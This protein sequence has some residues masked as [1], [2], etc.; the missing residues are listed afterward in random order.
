M[1][2]HEYVH[3]RTCEDQEV[4]QKTQRM[5]EVLGPQEKARD[6]QQGRANEKCA[7][8]PETTLGP[9][10]VMVLRMVVHGHAYSP[11]LCCAGIHVD[12]LDPTRVAS[13]CIRRDGEANPDPSNGWKVK[14][15]M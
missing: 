5:R 13:A 7:R 12:L 2:V 3:Q 15:S 4:G 10:V 6:Q 11:A 8:G 14:P 1:A 9:G